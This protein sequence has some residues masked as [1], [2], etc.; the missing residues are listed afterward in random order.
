MTDPA[1]AADIASPLTSAVALAAWLQQIA[2]FGVLTTD[3]ELRIRSWNQ[4]LVAHSGLAAEAV[5]GRRLLDVFP[6][7][8][9]RR[10]HERFQRALEGEISVLSTAL[11]QY[12]LPLRVTVPESGLPFML[13]TARIAPLPGETGVV[14]TI[15][16][17]EDVTQREFQAGILH[18][19]QEIDRLLSSSLAA[20]LHTTDPVRDIAEIFAKIM[21]SL[22]LDAYVSYLAGQR[23]DG[24]HLN[25]AAG[26]SPTHRETLAVC[27]VAESDRAAGKLL[28]A[29]PATLAAL[30][31]SLQQ[32]GWRGL[33]CFPLAIGERVIGVVAFGSY[34][35]EAVPPADIGTLDRISRYVAVALDRTLREREV[36]AASRAK[37]DFLAALSHELRTPLNPVL[38]MASDSALNQEYPPSA[39]E[40]F[41]TIEKNALLEARLI[42]DLLDLT[43]IE[44]GKLALELQRLD[45]HAVLQDALANVRADT[46]ERE[47][48][49]EVS[50]DAEATV[51]MGD[52]GRLQQVFWN[53]LKNA[54][55][56]TPRG[57]R[58]TV[59]SRTGPALDEIALE[60]SDSGIGMEP[61]EVS[62]V[63][64]A[65]AQGDH[66]DQGRGHRFGGLGLGL[67]ISRKLVELHAGKIAA[68]SGGRGQG[69][70]FTIA[71]PLLRVKDL[72]GSS[73]GERP[74]RQSPEATA[75]A[76]PA[77]RI[78]LV[79]DHE[80]TRAPL[81]RLLVRRGYDVV[82]VGT[83]A[84]ALAAADERRFD[85][86][87]SDI[88]LPDS[89]GFTLM[90][91]LRER[92][93]VCGIA[94]TG[95]GM[96]QDVAR[97]NE[98][99]FVDH[100]TKP[101][102]VTTLDRALTKVFERLLRR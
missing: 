93:A 91:T 35:R 11:H 88:G 31:R 47:L 62:R 101:I 76:R 92:H 96:D 45:V 34:A 5:L 38:L 25:A 14:G 42:D 77:G 55:K 40:A 24:F 3:T 21:P 78:L 29:L 9:E 90:R 54:V 82:A 99:G 69:S 98:A 32:I 52:A 95:Y 65:F 37:D 53:V 60:I 84:A 74:P 75:A 87:L 51:I 50:L 8:E 56:F 66:A 79:E 80:P 71:L 73:R 4:W 33:C 70:T 68:A 18:R 64:G 97:S 89:D 23:P 17:I 16:I 83:A 28:P 72:A 7:L 44:H 36:V 48:T 102:S 19:Q 22:G 61:H 26:V 46:S 85:V 41:R 49:I 94:L 2:P 6:A 10:L 59:R 20:L 58:I 39:R 43:R 15:T 27:P 67:A 100:L 86:V 12:L 63:F 81:T 30:A 13:Q 57:G 1:Q